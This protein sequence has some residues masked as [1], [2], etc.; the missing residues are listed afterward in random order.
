VDGRVSGCLQTSVLLILVRW[1]DEVAVD[2]GGA[3]TDERDEMGALTHASG[4]ELTRSA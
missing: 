2:E 1:F 4:S 3:G